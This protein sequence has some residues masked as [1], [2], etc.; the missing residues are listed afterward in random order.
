MIFLQRLI[1][2]FNFV[3]YKSFKDINQYC[4]NAI[5]YKNVVRC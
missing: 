2:L 4:A 5:I 3:Y 1:D